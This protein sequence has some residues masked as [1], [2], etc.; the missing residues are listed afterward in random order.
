MVEV[1][2]EVGF[3]A[4]IDGEILPRNTFYG[5]MQRQL[6]L[7]ELGIRL[8]DPMSFFEEVTRYKILQG[9]LPDKIVMKSGMLSALAGA[10]L[11]W[12]T[13]YEPEKIALVGLE[14]EG[15]IGIPANLV[16]N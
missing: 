8:L 14:Q 6:V 5:R 16:K 2:P 10:F 11:A 7:Y 1:L 4:W 13:K 3:C 15:R 12:Q 9:M